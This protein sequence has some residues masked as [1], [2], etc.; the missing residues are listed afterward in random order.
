MQNMNLLTKPNSFS[1]RLKVPSQ[2]FLW[3]E[4]TELE[5]VFSLTEYYFNENLASASAEESIHVHV[6]YGFGLGSSPVKQI[7]SLSP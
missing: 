6:V 1:R 3:Q 5:K 2:S 7:N 4:L